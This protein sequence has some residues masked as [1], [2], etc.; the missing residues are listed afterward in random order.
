M[1]LKT[2]TKIE[3][4]AL[5]IPELSDDAKDRLEIVWQLSQDGMTPKEISNLFNQNA[6]NRK[7]S[8]K[9][10]TSKD[11]GMMKLKYKKRLQ[12][13]K[14]KIVKIGDWEVQFFHKKNYD[15]CVIKHLKRLK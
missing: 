8:S 1:L 7:Y 14:Q 11:I 5:T 2:I 6:V 3:T 10:Y 9:Q 15:S 13:Q 12:R 4:R